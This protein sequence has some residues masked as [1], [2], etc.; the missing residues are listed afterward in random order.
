MDREDLKNLIN[1]AKALIK[2]GGETDALDLLDSVNW[3]KIRNVNALIEIS[4]L[5]EQLG[6]IEDSKMLLEYAHERSPI[7]RMI[8][9]HLTLVCVKM[10]EIEEAEEHLEEFVAI[11]PHDSKKYILRYNIAKA[12]G[13]DIREQI[14]ILEELKEADFLEDWAFE[15]AYLYYKVGE[16]DKCTALC[17]EIVIWF[18]DGPYVTKALELKMFYKPL[19]DD[20]A[21]KYQEL[22][23]KKKGITHF[24]QNEMLES[25]EV[26]HHDIDIATVEETPG[27]LNTVN[28][29]AEIKR[30]IEEIM[31]A[32]KEGEVT[33]NLENIKELIEEIPYLQEKEDLDELANKQKQD[34]KELDDSIESKFKELLEEDNDGQ[35]KMFVPDEPEKEEQVEGQMTLQDI[36]D[37]WERTQRATEE[38]IE[39][40]DELKLKQTKENALEEANQIMNKLEGVMP[41]LQAGATPTEIM[42]EEVLNQA[43]EAKA[44]EAKAAQ[45]AEAEAK[46]K[47]LADAR[48]NIASK[49]VQDT[50]DEIAAEIARQEA[51][52]QAKIKALT[53]RRDNDHAKMVE[54]SKRSQ[55]EDAHAYTVP[56]I[57][58]DG[59]KVDEGLKIPVIEPE[60]ANVLSADADKPALVHDGMPNWTPPVLSVEEINKSKVL[61]HTDDEPQLEETSKVVEEFIHSEEMPEPVNQEPEKVVEEPTHQEPEKVAEEPT[62]QEPEKVIEEPTRQEPEQDVDEPELTPIEV[63]EPLEEAEIDFSEKVKRPEVER[64]PASWETSKTR[65]LPVINVGDKDK[66]KL[67]EDDEPEEAFDLEEPETE[68]SGDMEAIEQIASETLRSSMDDLLKSSDNLDEEVDEDDEVYSNTAKTVAAEQPE[69]NG[70][71]GNHMIVLSKEE[72]DI[73]SYFMPIDGMEASICKALYNTKNYLQGKRD[74]GGHI[75]IQGIQGSGKT[76]LATS[77][78]K[79]LQSQIGLPSGGVGKVDGDKLNGKD[80]GKLFSKIQGG[81]LIIEQAGDIN[82]ETAIRLTLMMQN[83][84]SGILVILEDSKAGIE[85]LTRLSMEINREFTE[86]IVI[87]PFTIDELVLFAKKY[88][89]DCECVIDEMGILALYD[90]INII[91]SLDHPTA[92]QEVKEIMD[93]AMENADK[94]GKSFFGMFGNKKY[95]DKGFMIIRE[96][97]FQE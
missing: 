34:N 72:K 28:L 89:A 62:R 29:Q 57:N 85:R 27:H 17:D 51:E 20:Q 18:G 9:Y 4:N 46:A 73:F 15:L 47:E 6:H 30:N 2:S 39:S 31:E 77:I 42:K 5:Y 65:V 93:E 86:K 21:E 45:E 64:M 25:G 91:Q 69:D 32:T 56:K 84:K 83:D 54:E 61:R 55:E 1:E 76:M 8:L 22:T 50:Q 12:K 96:K 52:T 36:M 82:R 63:D 16:A 75:I 80:I 70:E 11:A 66:A 94:G 3:R 78:V 97:N 23:R 60:A 19:D 14:S 41:K 49:A 81:C 13:A 68:E 71:G 59:T 74:E 43:E 67:E 87:P 38:V 53:S 33:D 88:A 95:D 24:K 48:Q 58:A 35:L 44:A 37:D 79:V 10:E 26:I 90:R 40:A 7:G 92:I